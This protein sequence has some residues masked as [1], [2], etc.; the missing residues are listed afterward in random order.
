MGTAV[1]NALAALASISSEDVTGCALA[2][3]SEMRGQ[4]DSGGLNRALAPQGA[5]TDRYI[6]AA[7]RR[8]GEVSPDGVVHFTDGSKYSP[9]IPIELE[10]SL[11]QAAQAEGFLAL[12]RKFVYDLEAEDYRLETYR[13]LIAPELDSATFDVVVAKAD[14]ASGSCLAAL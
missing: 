13:S 12:L 7:M 4:L 3:D 11:N 1:A 10:V 2:F 14:A 5:F 9:G 8:L 6:R